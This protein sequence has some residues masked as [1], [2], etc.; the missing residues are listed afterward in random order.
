VERLDG[1]YLTPSACG[2]YLGLSPSRVVQY[3][4]ERRLPHLVTPG[5]RLVRRADLEAFA[6]ERAAAKA[7]REEVPAA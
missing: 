6:R 2:R 4:R 1:E 7:A 3:L 5:G